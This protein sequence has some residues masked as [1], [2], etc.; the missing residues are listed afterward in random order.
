VKINYE[1]S[2]DRDAAAALFFH[3]SEVC[4]TI[5]NLRKLVYT[6]ATR[7]SELDIRVGKARTGIRTFN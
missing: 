3:Q 6:P 4:A 1:I 7:N 2:G 5:T